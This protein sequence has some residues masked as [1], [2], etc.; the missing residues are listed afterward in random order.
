MTEAINTLLD[1]QT[2]VAALIT[3]L[4]FAGVTGLIAYYKARNTVLWLVLGGVLQLLALVAILLLPSRKPAADGSV[5]QDDA[6][7]FA[8]MIKVMAGLVLGFLILFVAGGGAAGSSSL[9]WFTGGI[10]AFYLLF[11]IPLAIQW[12]KEAYKKG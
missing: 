6:P 7:I 12:A 4:A 9:N 11:F 8:F 5:H 2:L 1:P 10:L 3:P